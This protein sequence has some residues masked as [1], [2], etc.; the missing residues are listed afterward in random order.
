M[1]RLQSALTRSSAL[2]AFS[3]LAI[4]T[5]SAD[6]SDQAFKSKKHDFGTVAVAAKTEYTFEFTNPL[7]RDLHIRSVRASCGCTTPIIKT[8]S[9]A[10]GQKGEIL[11]RFNTRTFKGKRGAT[12]TVIFD[13]PYYH[14]VRLR[15]DGYIRSDMVFH[16]GS[17]DF[18]KVNQG[19]EV[20]KKTML[21]YAGRSDWKV[22]DVESNRPWLIP[23]FK[24]TLR[25]SGRVDYEFN[26]KLREDAPKG[27]FQDAF[28]VI[29]NDRTMPRVPLNVSGSVE[30]ELSLFPQSIPLGGIKPGET[31][32]QKIIVRGKQPFVIESLSCE[33]WNIMFDPPKEMKKTHVIFPEFTPADGTVGP[34]KSPVIITTAGENPVSAKALLTAEIRVQ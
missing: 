16:P 28:V 34:Q 3:C 6:W 14:E 15:V 32:R 31:V 27:Y 22:L 13:R 7:Q 9:V 20:E 26:V 33:G 21:Y 29:T 2:V 19:D 12:L 24:E 25:G 18:G 23:S 10:P 30:S 17:I 11:A 5:A 8:Q 4:T 1:T